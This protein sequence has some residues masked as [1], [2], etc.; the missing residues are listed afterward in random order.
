MGR[1]AAAL[2]HE[3][4]SP[5]GALRSALQSGNALAAKKAVLSGERRDELEELKERYD[6]TAIES[7]ERLHQIVLR[8]QRFTNLD[9]NEILLVDLNSLLQDV[10][11]ILKAGLKDDFCLEL[12]FQPLPSILLR[13]QQISAVFS[14]LLNS[15]TEGKNC[16]GHVSLTTRQI[17]SHVEVTVEDQSKAMSAEELANIFDPAFKTR[18]GRVSRVIGASSVPVK[19]CENTEAILR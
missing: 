1:F 11:D 7:V 5:I 14:N 15:A 3:L 10:V 8:M 17:H 9:W 4:N 16:G 2:S 6:R 13:P 19:S 12:N 18:G